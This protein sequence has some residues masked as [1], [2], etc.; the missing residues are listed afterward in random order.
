VLRVVR[1]RRTVVVVAGVL[2]FAAGGVVSSAVQRRGSVQEEVVWLRA[3]LAEKREIIARQRLEMAEVAATADQLLRTVV[4]VRERAAEA[5]RL[6]QMEESRGAAPDVRLAMSTSD[7]S[8]ALLSEDVARTIQ[9]LAWI[10]GETANVGDSLTILSALLKDRPTA[11]SRPSLWP[12]RGP[13]TSRF[14]PRRSPYGG[15]T[16]LHPGI[17]IDARHGMPVT[18]G[19]DGEVVFAGR[20]SGYGRLVI[21]DH[22]GDVD[23]LYGH[24]SAIYV[25]EGEKVRRGQPIGA[26]GASGRATGAHL[27]YEVRVS[28]R[29]VDPRRYLVN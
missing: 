13:V 29:P 4:A 25:R 14:G 10:E 7:L 3:R 15:G 12:V 16:E 26:V 27:H 11:P 22:G 6:A 21:V 24:L 2:L 8:G 17:D 28:G 19:G 20:D 5:R 23:T 9:Q 18:A 1:G